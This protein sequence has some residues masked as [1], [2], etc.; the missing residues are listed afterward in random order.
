MAIIN[1]IKNKLINFKINF[2]NYKN[3][4]INKLLIKYVNFYINVFCDY[5]IVFL[6]EKYKK[7]KHYKLINKILIYLFIILNVVSLYPLI[8]LFN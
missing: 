8:F 2:I 6:R 4:L 3:K 1:K 5:R 7:L